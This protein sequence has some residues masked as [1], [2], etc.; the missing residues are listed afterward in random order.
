MRSFNKLQPLYILECEGTENMIN[1]NHCHLGKD[2]GL[3]GSTGWIF[4]FHT[5]VY[6][7]SLQTLPAQYIVATQLTM[8]VIDCNKSCVIKTD[9]I[10]AVYES[11]YTTDIMPLSLKEGYSKHWYRQITTGYHGAVYKPSPE[12]WLVLDTS[13]IAY[14]RTASI[15]VVTSSPK[16][17]QE[18]QEVSHAK[19]KYEDHLVNF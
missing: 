12:T 1:R 8:L 6:P 7:N 3:G 4:N 15:R 13:P 18:V 2:I 19:G 11:S 9:L 14:P 5:R 16:Q 17:N 10:L